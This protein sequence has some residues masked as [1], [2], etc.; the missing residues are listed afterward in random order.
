MGE[1]GRE[2]QPF[3]ID[4]WGDVWRHAWW[5]WGDD[6]GGGQRSFNSCSWGR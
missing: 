4:R 1:G 2:K 6:R 3:T 5:V